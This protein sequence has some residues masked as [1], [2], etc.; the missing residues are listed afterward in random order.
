MAGSMTLL[1]DRGDGLTP[2]ATKPFERSNWHKAAQLHCNPDQL[3]ASAATLSA[4]DPQLPT[5]LAVNTVNTNVPI[6]GPL[7]AFG[8]KSATTPAATGPSIHANVP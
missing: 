4:P 6:A 3:H 7:T 8:N 1:D 5:H 2:I